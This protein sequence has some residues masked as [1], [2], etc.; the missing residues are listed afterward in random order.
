MTSAYDARFVDYQI[1][2]SEGRLADAFSIAYAHQDDFDWEG[3]YP[4]DWTAEQIER[5]QS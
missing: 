1:A 2:M 4:E 3:E 5:H